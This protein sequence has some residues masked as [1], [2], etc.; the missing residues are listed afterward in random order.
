MFGLFDFWFF[1]ATYA[2]LLFVS[3]LVLY[4]Y[5]VVENEKGRIIIGVPF[6]LLDVLFNYLLI[7]V[8]PFLGDLP[9]RDTL[10]LSKRL[11]KIRLTPSLYHPKQVSVA[12]WVCKRLNRYDEGHC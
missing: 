1:M 2:V 5:R 9:T 10:T 8:P 4:K 7:F 3:Y 12:N 11:E 6:I